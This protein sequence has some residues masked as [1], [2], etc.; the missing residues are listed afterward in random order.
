MRRLSPSFL[1]GL[2]TGLIVAVIGSVVLAYT[3]AGTAPAPQPSAAVSRTASVADRVDTDELIARQRAISS[4]AS[5]PPVSLPSGVPDHGPLLF[6]V[7]S[8]LNGGG[9][10]TSLGDRNLDKVQVVGQSL[11]FE[12][13]RASRAAVRLPAD[14][15]PSSFVAVAKFDIVSGAGAVTLMFHMDQQGEQQHA[16]QVYTT[17][18]TEAALFDGSAGTRSL[19]RR[20][21]AVPALNGSATLAVMVNGPSIRIWVNGVEA[22]TATDGT[23]SQGSMGFKAGAAAREDPFIMRLTDLKVYQLPPTG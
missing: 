13:S 20:Q 2:L 16:V 10:P 15:Q 19:I 18:T 22:G 12:V 5:P 9:M 23:L 21:N 14:V 8:M 17:G 4:P 1:G 3:N 7:S 11:Q 6:D